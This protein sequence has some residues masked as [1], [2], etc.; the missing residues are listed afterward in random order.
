VSADNAPAYRIRRIQ[1][2]LADRGALDT[3]DMR[4]L[5]FDWW[6]TQAELLLPVMLP[7]LA[8]LPDGPARD[9]A[10][11]LR[12][13]QRAPV[14][15]PGAAGPLVFERWYLALAERVFRQAVRDELWVRMLKRNYLLNHALDRLLLEEPDSPWWGGARGRILTE[16]FAVAADSLTTELGPAVDRWRWD[17]RHAVVM[18]HEL[19]KALPLLGRWLDRG[20]YPWGGGAATVGRANYRYDAPSRVVH[21]ATVRMVAEMRP[22]GPRVAA[23]TSSGQ[24]G[25][26]MSEHY[27]DQIPAWLAGELD[28]IADRPD[29]VAGPRLRLE[30]QR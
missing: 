22:D 1:S 11:V 8:E 2:V 16:S 26:P 6:N 9:A 27:D 29:A 3:D 24:S 30:P 17:A 18:Q 14:N 19:G 20:P 28:P 13:W 5:Q 12:A 4:A 7:A 15:A 23:V 21:G 10:T 25:N